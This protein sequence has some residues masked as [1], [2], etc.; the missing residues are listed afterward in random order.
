[1]PQDAGNQVE[2]DELNRTYRPALISFFLRRLRNPADAEDL[3]QDVLVRMA[4]SER[5]DIRSAQAY[6]FRIATNLLRDKARRDRHRLEYCD[7]LTAD[8][9]LGVD[10]L[11]PCRIVAG[12][13]SLEALAVAIRNLPELTRNIFI[14]FRLENISRPDIAAAY[15]L[16]ERA[17]DHHLARAMAAVIAE[18]RGQSETP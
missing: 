8:G 5:T 12:E 14:C 1:M 15:H 2:L 18:L 10:V 13:K 4:R 9:D 7:T 3:A 17:V 16:T 6:V 11:D